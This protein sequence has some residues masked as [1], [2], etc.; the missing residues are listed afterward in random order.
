[1]RRIVVSG[2]VRQGFEG[3][4]DVFGRLGS[5]QHE[6]G[7]A[8]SIYQNGQCVADLSFG[9]YTTSSRQVVF[10]VSKLM[11]AIAL[12]RA[13]ERG[14]LELDAPLS[15]A[16]P[17]FGSAGGS[18]ITVR[19][20]LAHRTSLAALGGLTT[21]EEVLTGGDRRAVL[22]AARSAHRLEGHGYH[23]VTFGTVLGAVVEESLCTSVPEFLKDEV[24]DP[25]GVDL[26]L[27]SGATDVRPLLFT[28]PT[29][30]LVPRALSPRADGLLSALVSDPEL[31][32]S[33]AFLKA[34][35]AS[36]GVVTTASSLARI[37]ASTLGEVDGVRLLAPDTLNGM[38]KPMSSGIDEVLGVPTSFGSGPQLSFPRL[39]IGR[40]AFG[41]EGAGGSVA[42]A[43]QE[44]ELGVGFTTNLFPSAPGA[45]PLFLGLL[46]TIQHLARELA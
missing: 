41:H 42:F 40:Q 24:A 22:A 46:P 26:E 31:F 33:D 1:M 21:P 4:A 19:D 18:G 44:L 17:A 11:L 39:P 20:V 5:Q 10:S 28:E 12:H 2:N 7:A 35:V 6:G 15:E 23:A 34:G 25:L 36:M 43:D 27:G 16:W 9:D 38:T 8:V 37:M 13:A 3:L 32:N 30:I 29:E 14:S 45:S